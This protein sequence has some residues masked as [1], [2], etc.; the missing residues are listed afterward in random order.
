MSFRGFSIHTY[1]SD[2]TSV[3][4]VVNVFHRSVHAIPDSIYSKDQKSAWAP[5]CMDIRGWEQRLSQ[6]A[7]WVALDDKNQECLGFI[8]LTEKGDIEC[9]YICPRVQ[10]QGIAKA[11]FVTAAEFVRSQYP[12]KTSWSVDAS[13]V[14]YEFFRKHGFMP[15]K[16][17]RIERFGLVIENTTMTRSPVGA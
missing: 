6:A 16:R 7:V 3:R 17:N 8:E 5:D 13:D 4:D 15:A 11:L 10:R 12:E 1:D 14:A 2:V 9:L